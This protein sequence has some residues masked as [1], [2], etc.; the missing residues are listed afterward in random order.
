M[1]LSYH[2]TTTHNQMLDSAQQ[3]IRKTATALNLPESTVHRLLEPEAVHEFTVTLT[4]DDG[5]VRLFKGFRI[6]HNSMLGP[7]KGGLRFHPQVTREE[8]QALA[9]LMTIKCAV[10][11]IPLGGGKGGLIADPKKL[12][13]AELE[14]LTRAFGRMIAPHIGEHV[15]IPAPDVNT[16]GTIINWMLEE[17]IEFKKKTTPKAE[18][19]PTW[20]ATYTGKPVNTGGS[21]GRTEATGRGGVYTMIRLIEILK[22]SKKVN[23]DKKLTIAVQGFGNVGYHFAEIA[24][25]EGFDIVAVSDSR[26]GITSH[27]SPLNIPLLL[28]CKKEQGGVSHMKDC[29][30]ITN[31][32]LLELPVDILVPS[33][34]ENVIHVGNMKQIKAQIIV[35][36]ANGPITEEAYQYLSEK[37]VIIIPDVLA[38]AGGVIVSYLEWV[39]NLDGE[40][41]TEDTVN[42]RLK[43]TIL[44]AFDTVWSRSVDRK[45]PL[46]QA[47]F[48]VAIQRIVERYDQ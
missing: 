10:A 43:K 48:E 34:L 6:Q 44:D 16:N 8:V 24:S 11:G 29:H 33:A 4:H 5:T 22:E 36:M 9:T 21:L 13:V 41:W 38:N 31:D 40:S 12:S 47:A 23:V 20:I 2:M 45:I 14:R 27:N 26:G 25:Q 18:T 37:G 42:T 30:Q 32:E 15:D 39:Q 3:I 46:K 17:Y 28:K 1:I 19:N 7:Y 35:E